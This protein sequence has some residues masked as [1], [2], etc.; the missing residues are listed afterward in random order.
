MKRRASKRRL[1]LRKQEQKVGLLFISPWIVGVLV[2]LLFP[3][4]R[5]MYFSFNNVQYSAERGYIYNW[6]GWENYR[7]ILT[8]DVDFV[9]ELQN[10]IVRIITYV[11]VIIALSIVIA[12]LLNAKVKGTNL[13]RLIFFLPVIILNGQ[14]LDNLKNNGEMSLEVGGLIFRMV[15][16]LVP[17]LFLDAILLLFQTIQ[18][19]LWFSGVPILIFLA[20]LQKVDRHIYEAAEIDGASVWN[21]FWKIT[22]PALYPLVGVSIVFLVVYLANFD[23]NAIN[24]IIQAARTNPA[25]REGYASALSILYAVIQ[26]ILI[27]V[28]YRIFHRQKKDVKTA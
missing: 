27:L 3:L 15:S 6:V 16:I 19:I 11:P 7:R 13:F 22:L 23:G 10:F 24:G 8:I 20:A 2:F 26:T 4:I 18:E 25:R 5:T 1:E 9:L 17:P 14:L 21:I 12:V 28:L